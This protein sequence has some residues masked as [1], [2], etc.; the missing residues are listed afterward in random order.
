MKT[1]ST[2][3]QLEGGNNYHAGLSAGTLKHRTLVS[4]LESH[5]FGKDFKLTVNMLTGTAPA[6]GSRYPPPMSFN[7]EIAKGTTFKVLR[8][9]SEILDGVARLPGEY[10]HRSAPCRWLAVANS[11]NPFAGESRE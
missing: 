3:R 9:I 11:L 4:F 1:S 10:V 8:R 5:G 6:C 7:A 2:S